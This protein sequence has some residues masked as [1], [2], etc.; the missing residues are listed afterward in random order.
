M[1]WNTLC[2]ELRITARQISWFGDGI[3]SLHLCAGSF[4]E[5]LPD[6][7]P[8]LSL[9]RSDLRKLSFAGQRNQRGGTQGNGSEKPDAV[10]S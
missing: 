5:M 3:Q 6:G 8:I 10:S 1:G 7:W 2:K 4:E 9:S